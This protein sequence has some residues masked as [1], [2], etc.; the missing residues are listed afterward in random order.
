MLE[1]RVLAG[2]RE[3]Q[4][5]GAHRAAAGVVG[6]AVGDRHLRLERHVAA[7]QRRVVQRHAVVEDAAAHAEHRLLVQLVARPRGA[8]RTRWR[9]SPRSRA[10]RRGRAP[11]RRG[12]APR[13]TA[14]RRPR[15]RRPAAP[16]RCSGPADQPAGRRVDDRRLCAGRRTADRSSRCCW[17]SSTT[18][19][20]RPSG[21]RL[22]SSARSVGFHE[23][24]T[25]TSVASDRHLVK[26]RCPSSA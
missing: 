20:S 12:P 9:A 2:D 13:P 17:S 8:A 18:A 3:R 11:A 10:A 15:S 22:R 23:S 1:H 4:V 6:A 7:E 26:L 25:K 24:C 16:C 14:W 19:A 5:L 21:R